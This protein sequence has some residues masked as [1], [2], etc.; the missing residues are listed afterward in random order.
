MEHG[1]P[2]EWEWLRPQPRDKLWEV[3]SPYTNKLYEKRKGNDELEVD[4]GR[5]LGSKE[6]P[7]AH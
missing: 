1:K 5:L 7:F 4:P 6:L 3:E 2:G